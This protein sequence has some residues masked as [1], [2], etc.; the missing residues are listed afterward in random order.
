M[1]D[2]VGVMGINLIPAGAVTLPVNVTEKISA[3]L[4]TAMN[5]AASGEKLPVYIWTQDVDHAEVEQQVEA[6]TGLSADSLVSQQKKADFDVARMASI[7]QANQ[8]MQ[9]HLEETEAVREQERIQTNAY[10]EARRQTYVAEYSAKNARSLNR[11]GVNEEDILFQSQYSPMVVV[12]MSPGEIASASK[13]AAVVS[14]GLCQ[15]SIMRDDSIASSMETIEADVSVTVLTGE[16]VKIGQIEPGAPNASDARYGGKLTVLGGNY[17][18]HATK[19]A[20]VIHNMAPEAQIYS[21]GLGEEIYLSTFYSNVENLLN[22]GVRVINMS[23]SW[24]RSNKNTDY[25]YSPTEQWLDHISGTHEVTIVKSAGNND[26]GL[27][28]ADTR[29]ST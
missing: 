17:S 20:L 16:G 2:G 11:L 23:A 13:N 26:P 5:E 27:N 22:L 1:N 29:L 21:V 7:E 28:V 24:E 4:Q 25:W 10:V 19:V 8:T 15:K 6:K 9:A 3:S 14:M 12:N 18:D